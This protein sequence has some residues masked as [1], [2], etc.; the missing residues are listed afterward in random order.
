MVLGGG[1]KLFSKP[2]NP[3][4]SCEAVLRLLINEDTYLHSFASAF[5]TLVL[6]FVLC[7]LVYCPFLVF[8]GLDLTG[9]R[10]SMPCKK[11]RSTSGQQQARRVS[12]VFTLYV[13]SPAKVSIAEPGPKRLCGP[14]GVLRFS[15]AGG[16][17][18]CP[19]FI[20]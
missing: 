3:S 5:C 9:L 18:Q 13:G 19:A 11:N 17:V 8:L 16:V 4:G 7:V 15:G 1:T 14:R 2:R 20:I 10:S 6:E 12:K